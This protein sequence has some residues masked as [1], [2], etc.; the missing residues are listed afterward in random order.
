MVPRQDEP[1]CFGT[2]LP[3]ARCDECP[4]GLWCRDFT[5]RVE[6]A[7]LEREEHER[8]FQEQTEEEVER[9]VREYEAVHDG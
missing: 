4:A 9:L 6:T 2:F 8:W 5:L 7:A 3:K 1:S